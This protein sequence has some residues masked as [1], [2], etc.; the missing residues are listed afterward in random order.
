MHGIKLILIGKL[1]RVLDN[2]NEKQN[3]K[4]K[5]FLKE[6]NWNK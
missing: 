1:E 3:N 5:R 6:R 2:S 4:K